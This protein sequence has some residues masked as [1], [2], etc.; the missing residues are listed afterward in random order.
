MSI[1]I[2]V[3]ALLFPHVFPSPQ[4][5]GRYQG[6]I[7]H[8]TNPSIQNNRVNVYTS[9]AGGWMNRS[10]TRLAPLTKALNL[11]QFRSV[12]LYVL[13]APWSGLRNWTDLFFNDGYFREVIMHDCIIFQ[14]AY[15]LTF[16][17]LNKPNRLF[18]IRPNIPTNGI[19]IASNQSS[20]LSIPTAV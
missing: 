11:Y 16:A 7:T 14:S 15:I 6:C 2:C 19:R 12:W 13:F 18:P 17:W 9:G 5:T 8:K 10:T 4:H 1:I 3:F 20:R